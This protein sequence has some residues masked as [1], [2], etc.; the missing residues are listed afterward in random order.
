[1][2][3]STLVILLALGGCSSTGPFDASP[4]DADATAT[5]DVPAPVVT[6]TAA[7]K[8][9]GPRTQPEGSEEGTVRVSKEA[10]DQRKRL[11]F[12]GVHIDRQGKA[13]LVVT[14]SADDL[15]RDFDGQRVWVK[16]E[17]YAPEGRA[18]GGEH[19]RVTELVVADES[20]AK[21]YFGFGPGKTM[22][23]E[24]RKQT[25]DKG[26]KSEG[27]TMLVFIDAAGSTH[28]VLNQ[29]GKDEKEHLGKVKVVARSVEISKFVAH[30]G[31]PAIWLTSVEAL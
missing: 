13:P 22:N 8:T 14:Y 2:R 21:H 3:S 6:A 19:A 25:G 31:I 1:V 11:V 9:N 4:E 20:A 23:G 17:T 5:V 28:Q 18:I 12:R 27:S 30:V 26:T 24:L 16:Y 7:A 15:W 29:P 10:D